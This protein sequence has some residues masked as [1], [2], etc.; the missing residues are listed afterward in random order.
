[1]N[2]WLKY[3]QKI[4][5]KKR[6]DMYEILSKSPVFKGI[7]PQELET[8]LKQVRT[9][10]K[11]YEK[12]QTAAYRG[13]RCRSLLILVEGSIRGEMLDY[14]GKLM[15]VETVT[16][17][18]PIAAAFIF[19]KKNSFPVDAVAN[20][21]VVM[22]SIPKESLVRL[23]QLNTLVLTNYLD[24]VSNKTHFLTERLWFM[25]FKTIREKLAHYI[26]SLAGTEGDSIRL[27]RNMQEL[28]E[29]FGVSRPS[30]SRVVGQMTAEGI[31]RVNRREVE[32]LDRRRLEEII[33]GSGG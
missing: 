4:K 27:S 17:P 10:L 7:P 22:L 16:A 29:F 2:Q 33:E 9:R 6:N 15:Q 3:R 13:D 32:I 12:G 11:K 14:S 21:N 28:S 18:K 30:L 20:V 25:S 8:L 23:M 19:G 5:G 24:L 26:L 31:I 1:V